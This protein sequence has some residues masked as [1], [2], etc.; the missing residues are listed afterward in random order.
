MHTFAQ[1]LSSLPQEEK[2]SLLMGNG[3]SQAWSPQIFNYRSIL[4]NANLG[5]HDDLILSQ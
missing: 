3:F 5:D 1:A 4:D 2:P